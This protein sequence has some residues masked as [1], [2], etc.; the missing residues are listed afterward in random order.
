MSDKTSAVPQGFHTLTPHLIVRDADRAIEFYRQAFGAELQGGIARMSNGKVMHALLRI[1]NSN[2]MLND[3]MPEYGALSPLSGG[4]SSVTIHVYT[5]N[6]DA[7]FARATA[8]GAQI[9]MPLMDQFWGDRY[10]VVTDP[11][12]HKWSLASHVKDLSPEEMHRAM[13]EA[14]AKM[15]PP[16]TARKT[17]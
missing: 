4:S 13:N 2:L 1:G 15:P 5:E 10:G 9:K 16:S 12:G 7:A 3:E 6:V 14:M 17:A 11:Y 8:A